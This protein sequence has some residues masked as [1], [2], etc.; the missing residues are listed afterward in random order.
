MTGSMSTVPPP[1]VAAAFSADWTARRAAL[2][3]AA[4]VVVGK[5][6]VAGSKVMWMCEE[7]TGNLW[8]GPRERATDTPVF[9]AWRMAGRGRPGGRGGVSGSGLP[10]L[11][12][13]GW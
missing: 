3:S 12:R 4:G 8:I 10:D 9:R 2:E 11:S 1:A 7:W 6:D 5:R 13:V